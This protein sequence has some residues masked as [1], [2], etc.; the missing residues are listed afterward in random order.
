MLY[1]FAIA[2]SCWNIAIFIQIRECGLT[3][4]FLYAPESFILADEPNLNSSV[5]VGVWR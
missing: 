3:L 2:F 1:V 5:G 4:L